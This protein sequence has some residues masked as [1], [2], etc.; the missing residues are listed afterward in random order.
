MYMMLKEGAKRKP[1]FGLVGLEKQLGAEFGMNAQ[2]L[3]LT[4]EAFARA[5]DSL[6]LLRNGSSRAV[7]R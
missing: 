2:E 3:R 6:A 1:E 7:D 4:G 5:F